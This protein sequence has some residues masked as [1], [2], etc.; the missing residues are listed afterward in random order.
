V[1]GEGQ[2]IEPFSFLQT[3]DLHLDTPFVGLSNGAPPAVSARLRDA[4]LRSWDRIVALALERRVDFVVVAGDVFESE[5]RTLMGQLAFASGLARLAEV[6]IPAAVVTGNHD[7]LS[8]WEATVEWPAGALRFGSDEVGA[9][10]I[11][12]GGKE[13]A[14]VYGISYGTKIERRDLA[15]MFH[16]EADVPFAVGLLHA[17]IGPNERHEP[18]AP[19]T[20][21]VLA[22]SGIDYWALG[23]IHSRRIVRASRPCVVYAGNPQG[24]DPGET[25]PRGVAVVMVGSDA[26]PHPEFVDTDVVRW[27]IVDLDVTSVSS[28]TRLH[29]L[30]RTTLNERRDSAGRSL[31]ARVRF[32]G[33][34][35]LHDELRRVHVLRDLEVAVRDGFPPEADPFVWVESLRDLTRS[36]AETAYARGADFVSEFEALVAATRASLKGDV[37][38]QEQGDAH[39]LE[40][41]PI[42]AELFDDARFRRVAADPT[43]ESVEGLAGGLNEARVIALDRLRTTG[44]SR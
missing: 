3:G 37:S 20:D 25:E 17:T 16:R 23:H 44:E 27:T 22:D 31:V 34:T 33:F 19:T 43:A 36:E 21:G 38:G 18:Y 26:V 12:R 30:V 5:T 9:M 8:G 42:A 39:A 4:T 2:V 29:E 35:P 13:I 7:P 15:A 24:R 6:G 32:T 1:P 28:M 14:R 40:L 41:A 11:V 10:P